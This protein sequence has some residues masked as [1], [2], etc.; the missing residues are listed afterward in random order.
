LFC[1]DDSSVN[2]Q[3]LQ[4]QPL[5]GNQEVSLKATYSQDEIFFYEGMFARLTQNG[6]DVEA[7][8]SALFLKKSGV[9]NDMLKNIW[10]QVATNPMKLEK[11]EF[12]HFCKFL[13]CIQMNAEFN[14]NKEQQLAKFDG[15][16]AKV[17]IEEQRAVKKDHSIN[18]VLD[19][20]MTSKSY[21]DHASINAQKDSRIPPSM[22][23]FAILKEWETYDKFGTK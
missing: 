6:T 11:E 18:M 7:K 20:H 23:E 16:D 22:P 17:I 1:F 12:F 4:N 9:K 19:N 5:T 21:M 14:I 10:R 8:Q 13:S 3:W 15:I 2:S